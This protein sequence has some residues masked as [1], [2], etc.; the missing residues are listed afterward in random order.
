MCSA[1]QLGLYGTRCFEKAVASSPSDIAS[2]EQAGMRCFCGE[3][4]QNLACLP[5]Q[6]V[7]RK[8]YKKG[9]KKKRASITNHVL[10]L[11]K[12][13]VSKIFRLFASRR[14]S[15]HFMLRIAAFTG[16]I[17]HSVFIASSESGC[18]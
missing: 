8:G 13:R 4:I 15:H 17:C 7:R 9:T 1:I 16:T 2:G 10:W 14:N 6:F 3:Q 5:R 11:C 12:R 18:D